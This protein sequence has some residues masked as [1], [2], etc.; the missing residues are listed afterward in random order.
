MQQI[1]LLVRCSLHAITST[2][3]TNTT[4]DSAIKSKLNYLTN[5]VISQW[6]AVCPNSGAYMSESDIQESDFQLAFY[7]SNYER[8]Y[9]LKQR[10]DPKSFFYAPTGVGS[11]E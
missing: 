7:G 10:Y 9:K 2:E 6:R 8:L 4:S 3:W 1:Q 11:E 5:N